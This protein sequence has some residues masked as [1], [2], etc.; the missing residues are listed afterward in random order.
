MINRC[1]NQKQRTKLTW[2]GIQQGQ[3]HRRSGR[4]WQLVNQKRGI[5]TAASDGGWNWNIQLQPLPTHNR[6]VAYKLL[7]H[8]N[9]GSLLYATAWVHAGRRRSSVT[10]LS[11]TC[12]TYAYK[13]CAMQTKPVINNQIKSQQMCARGRGQPMG[14]LDSLS[15]ISV[16]RLIANKL[17]NDQINTQ[18]SKSK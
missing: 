13:L 11:H 4:W 5:E 17:N 2:S 16:M 3:G 15:M 7:W 6:Q 18:K 1:A 8:K 9:N 12:C 10:W 14:P